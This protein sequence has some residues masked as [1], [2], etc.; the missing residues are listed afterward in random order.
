MK[1]IYEF[2][3]KSDDNDYVDLKIFQKAKS[4]Y[5][6]LQEIEH[7]LRQI[8]KGYVQENIE[9]IIDYIFDIISDSGIGDIE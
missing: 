7:Y 5:S 3:N 9:D 2:S 1:V 4:M 6:S 8:K